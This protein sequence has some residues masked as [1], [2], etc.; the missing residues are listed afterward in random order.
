MVRQYSN[1]KSLFLASL[2]LSG[3]GRCCWGPHPQ[4][5]PGEVTR[6]SS[7]P[8]REELPYFLPAG[9]GWRRGAAAVAGSGEE[10]SA[11]Q[12]SNAGKT[13]RGEE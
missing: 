1:I 2:V 9:G 11:L 4:L 7:E 5:P 10:L 8:R 13:R 3:P 12:L 6:R